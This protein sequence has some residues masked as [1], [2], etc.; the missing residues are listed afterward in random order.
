MLAADMIVS[1][2][3][4]Q[5]GMD[6][7]SLVFGLSGLADCENQVTGAER[8]LHSVMHGGGI[9]NPIHALSVII[10]SMKKRDGKNNY[11]WIFYDDVIDLTVQSGMK[12]QKSYSTKM[13]TAKVL[14]QLKLLEKWDTQHQKVSVPGLRLN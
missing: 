8:D 7:P 4:G 3:S 1:S 6:Q 9:A 11:R 2:D 10:S 14:A 13:I 5:S 12:L